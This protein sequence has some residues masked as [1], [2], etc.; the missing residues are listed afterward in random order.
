[1]VRDKRISSLT[2]SQNLNEK[3]TSSSIVNHGKESSSIQ[4]YGYINENR[5][6]IKRYSITQ[7]LP[8]RRRESEDQ[9][10]N[11]IKRETKRSGSVD[12]DIP[13][14]LKKFSVT[15]I[16]PISGVER[17]I[18]INQNLQKDDEI[19]RSLKN[20]IQLKTI[21]INEKEKE[22]KTTEKN[23]DKEIENQKMKKTA[24]TQV[25]FDILPEKIH[26]YIS[27]TE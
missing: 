10:I 6:K 2:E 14:K 11:I 3:E 15:K 23:A 26:E 20:E 19:I 21:I 16:I 25:S 7:I 9:L 18:N 22:A 13:T 1:M 24:I 5:Q 12:Q 17:T 4:G 27:E 8:V